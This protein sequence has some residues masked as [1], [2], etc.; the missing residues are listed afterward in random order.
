MYA[1]LP[2]PPS[3][4]ITL[5][6][7]AQ[8][9]AEYVNSVYLKISY[10]QRIPLCPLSFPSYPLLTGLCVLFIQEGSERSVQPSPCSMLWQ[11]QMA[12]VTMFSNL[13][14]QF[15]LPH[16]S[17]LFHFSCFGLLLSAW[18]L[19]KYHSF[20]QEGWK[21]RSYIHSKAVSLLPISKELESII[22]ADIDTFRLRNNLIYD[23]K[24]VLLLDH[25]IWTCCFSTISNY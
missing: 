13:V 18:K 22:A 19:V 16:L 25:S 5:Q 6:R 3:P 21:I 9:K 24:F 12:S 14:L 8:D 1:P 10:T 4:P 11:A 7:F 20:S 15:L 17:V 2:S 23:H